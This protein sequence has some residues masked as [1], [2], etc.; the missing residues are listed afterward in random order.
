MRFDIWNRLV[1]VHQ[2]DSR[3]DRTTFS[4]SAVWDEL[5][6]S[7]AYFRFISAFCFTCTRRWNKTE[8]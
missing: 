2:C 4:S 7:T 1:V 6:S 3:T 5:Y 8:I